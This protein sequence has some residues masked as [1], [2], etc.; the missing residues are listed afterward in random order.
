MS[1]ELDAIILGKNDICGWVQILTHGSRYTCNTKMINGEEYFV[2]K[3][4]WHK[5]SDYATSNT[6]VLVEEDGKIVEKS[7]F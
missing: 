4:E 3:N 5:V 7:Y 1:D 2:F 6:S